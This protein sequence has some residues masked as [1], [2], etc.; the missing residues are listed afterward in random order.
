MNTIKTI[1]AV[2][3]VTNERVVRSLEIFQNT[4]VQN[5]QNREVQNDCVY[6]Y[7]YTHT[8]T[9]THTNIYIIYI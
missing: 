6:I 1:H 2:P 7:L 5:E 4:E 9:Y 8:P 3:C